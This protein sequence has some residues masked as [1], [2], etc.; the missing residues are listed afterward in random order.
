MSSNRLAK[1]IKYALWWVPDKMYLQLYY[2]AQF[3]KFCNFRNP[4]TYNEKLQWLKLND[5]K[6]LYSKLVD[7]YEVRN[8]V[9]TIIGGGI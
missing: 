4:K 5:R 1:K 6:P 8:Y 7:K 2:F 9:E 3:K